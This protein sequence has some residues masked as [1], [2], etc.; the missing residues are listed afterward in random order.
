MPRARRKRTTSDPAATRAA[1]AMVMLA[2]VP[3]TSSG[4]AKAG[5][6]SGLVSSGARGSRSGWR[7]NTSASPVTTGAIRMTQASQRQRGEAATR[8]G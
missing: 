3:T 4:P 2:A 5:T 1:S 6:A 7:L 8:W